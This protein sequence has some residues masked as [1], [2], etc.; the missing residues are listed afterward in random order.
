MV[1]SHIHGVP[2]TGLRFFN[3]YGNGQ[4]AD[5]PYSGVISKFIQQAK[6]GQALQIY[7]D[8]QQTRDFIHVKDV[9][10]LTLAAMDNVSTKAKVYNL[11]SGSGTSINALAK[12]IIDLSGQALDI[13]Y[14]PARAGD[15][16]DS[17]G[18]PA[19]SINDLKVSPQVSLEDGLRALLT[20]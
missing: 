19:L 17:V 10:N 2:T 1:A 9:A 4:K 6:A 12:L 20:T 15:I 8:G 14:Q 5:S 3:V 13:D 18:E 11:C 16:L 7:G